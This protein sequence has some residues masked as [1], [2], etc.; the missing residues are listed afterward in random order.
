MTQHTYGHGHT[1]THRHR[2][3]THM[4]TDIPTHDTHR[5]YLCTHMTHTQTQTHTVTHEMAHRH[6]WTHTY[7]CL[8][9]LCMCASV[10]CRVCVPVYV[11][12]CMSCVCLCL[13]VCVCVATCIQ[14][15]VMQV[16]NVCVHLEDPQLGTQYVYKGS[17]YGNTMHVQRTNPMGH[18][19]HM[20]RGPILWDSACKLHTPTCMYSISSEGFM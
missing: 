3:T 2:H 18:D 7:V 13:C 16:C 6:T 20:Y 10:C 9:V 11:C 12:V 17:I 8:C 5:S 1:Q 19:V 15:C 14:W 4:H